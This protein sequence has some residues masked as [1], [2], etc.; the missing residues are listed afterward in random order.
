ME[1]KEKFDIM[2]HSLVPKHVKLNEEEK[3]E[4]LK[5]YN[6]SLK[7]LPSIIDKDPVVKLLNAVPDDVIKIVRKSQTS[8]ESSYYRVIVH[9]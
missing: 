3:K 9:G 6:I 7:Q 2:Q 4:L 1:E 5:K 8:G